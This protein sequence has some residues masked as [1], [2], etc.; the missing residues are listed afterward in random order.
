MNIRDAGYARVVDIEGTTISQQDIKTIKNLFIEKDLRQRIG[1]N[2]KQVNHINDD[3]I[4]LL[5]DISK[6]EKV[7]VF[8]LNNDIYLSFFVLNADKYV[9]IYLDERD[10]CS[11]KNLLIYRRFKLLKSA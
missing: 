4:F 8:N 2:L 6:I 3:F 7:S 11:Q 10:F 5:K 9:D 1:I